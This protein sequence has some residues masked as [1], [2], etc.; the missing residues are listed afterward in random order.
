[1]SWSPLCNLLLSCL[2]A[3]CLLLTRSTV[4]SL[5]ALYQTLR[6]PKPQ[7]LALNDN[8]SVHTLHH[9]YPFSS[10]PPLIEKSLP[11][12]PLAPSTLSPPPR[13]PAFLYTLAS[14]EQSCKYKQAS[15]TDRTAPSVAPVSLLVTLRPSPSPCWP[16]REEAES[17]LWWNRDYVLCGSPGRLGMWCDVMPVNLEEE[18]ALTLDC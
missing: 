6:S 2:T 17:G 11:P 3:P 5:E 8:Q 1:M 13:D 15:R 10:T 4:C 9:L 12:L 7:R 16:E 14:T 18:R